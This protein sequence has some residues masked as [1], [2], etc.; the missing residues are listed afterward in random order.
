MKNNNPLIPEE[1]LKAKHMED[2]VSDA[3][4]EW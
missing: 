1:P 3:L 4:Y 2:F